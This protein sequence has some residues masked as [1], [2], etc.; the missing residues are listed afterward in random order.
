M[1]LVKLSLIR[2]LFTPVQ[3]SRSAHSCRTA[4][5]NSA[6]R[7]S[8]TGL[9]V[10]HLRSRRQ[11]RNPPRPQLRRNGA[12]AMADHEVSISEVASGLVVSSES[13]DKAVVTSSWFRRRAVRRRMGNGK[14]HRRSTSPNTRRDRSTRL[15]FL[16]IA[17]P[18]RW[19]R[20][21]GLAARRT[22]THPPLRV[23]GSVSAYDQ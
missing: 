4:A 13:V 19:L 21:G 20:N 3:E 1:I 14:I 5:C 10:L 12:K 18:S 16:R 15:L 17:W 22:A 11:T 6:K 7:A 8:Q 2:A 23:T 9:R